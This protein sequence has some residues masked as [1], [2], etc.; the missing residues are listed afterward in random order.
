MKYLCVLFLFVSASVFPQNRFTVSGGTVRDNV[1]G[2][3]WQAE[4]N[5]K[6]YNHAEALRY[7]ETLSHAGFSD[8]LL[9]SVKQLSSL[10]DR[11]RADP[12]ADPI[13][14]MASG[15]YWSSTAFAPDSGKAWFVDF[16]DGFVGGDVRTSDARARCV[17]SGK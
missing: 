5:G 15:W 8:W 10:V 9:P 17:R 6:K 2:L 11:G 14:K 3:V 7:C 1:T 16:H 12:A 13:L 4:D